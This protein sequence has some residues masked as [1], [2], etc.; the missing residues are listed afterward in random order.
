MACI[1]TLAEG[2]I[3]LFLSLVTITMH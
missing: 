2:Q 1:F 3:G